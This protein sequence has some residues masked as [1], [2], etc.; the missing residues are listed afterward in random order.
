MSYQLIQDG[1]PRVAYDG[2]DWMVGEGDDTTTA[3]GVP[4]DDPNHMPGPYTQTEAII[5]EGQELHGIRFAVQHNGLKAVQ[6]VCPTYLVEASTLSWSELDGPGSC[7]NRWVL[8][9][10]GQG[11]IT[12]F[13]TSSQE[14]VPNRNAVEGAL[15]NAWD[16]SDATFIELYEERSW[17]IADQGL[18]SR[19]TLAA[20]GDDFHR[21]RRD[22]APGNTLP[23]YLP[24]DGAT[25]SFE[26]AFWSVLPGTA[27][28]FVHGHKCA[29]NEHAW[30][31]I[32]VR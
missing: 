9:E 23:S 14:K 16:S 11:Q 6:D 29:T 3:S 27:L 5:D 17:E 7:P 4:L 15:Q 2:S 19:K 21:R 31:Q 24:L 1:F 13:Q 12:G 25:G 28:Y 18:P 20:W 32:D 8:R 30:L 26:H 10:G 22:D